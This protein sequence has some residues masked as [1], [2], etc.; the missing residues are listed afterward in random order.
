MRAVNLATARRRERARPRDLD[1]GYTPSSHC[2]LS[3]DLSVVVGCC[4]A[5]SLEAVEA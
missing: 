3:V 5:R 4:L 2:W 1:L